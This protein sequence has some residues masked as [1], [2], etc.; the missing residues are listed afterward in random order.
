MECPRCGCIMEGGICNNCGFPVT[1]RAFSV[2]GIRNLHITY[3][4]PECIALRFKQK[5]GGD[6]NC[7]QI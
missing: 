6:T 5:K 3:N 2:L 7:H 4:S 1:M